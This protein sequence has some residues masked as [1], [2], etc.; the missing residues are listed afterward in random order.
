MC[1]DLCICKWLLIAAWTAAMP[2]ENVEVWHGCV[3]VSREERAASRAV[4]VGFE[5]REYTS[6]L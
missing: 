2:L 6:P 4:R 1:V 3:V 5:R